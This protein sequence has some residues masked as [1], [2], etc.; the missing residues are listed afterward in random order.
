MPSRRSIA[1][2]SAVTLIAAATTGAT[3][4]ND[5]PANTVFRLI[6]G[7]PG[8]EVPVRGVLL[9]Q[10]EPMQ[11]IQRTTP[12]ELRSDRRLVFAAFEPAATETMLRL[13]MVSGDAE[14]A[15]VTAPRVMVGRRIG[16]VASEFVQ[17]Y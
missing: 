15:K 11:V 8:L 9:V 16:G 5:A 12:F 17:G 10:D 1:L 3:P 6:S 2:A 7:T 13:E 14:P 4:R